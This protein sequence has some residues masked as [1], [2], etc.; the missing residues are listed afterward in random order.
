MFVEDSPMH[1]DIEK[2]KS[3]LFNTKVDLPGGKKVMRIALVTG[4]SRGIGKAISVRLGK[5]GYYVIVNYRN[6]ETEAKDTLEKIR[7]AG[8][9]GELMQFD[10]SSSEEVNRVLN[11][12]HH[13][14]PNKQIGVLV[15]NAGIA[16]D[17]LM[18]FMSDQE[19]RDVMSNQSGQL[20]FCKQV[21]AYRICWW[22]NGDGS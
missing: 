19:W 4:G 6:G 8:G 3:Y 10:V 13:L 14:N 21:P 16:R 5:E 20:L 7:Q 18:V 12:W 1:K 9:D 2:V 22:A 17:E 15:N 11:Q